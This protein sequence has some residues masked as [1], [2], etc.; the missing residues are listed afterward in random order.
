MLMQIQWKNAPLVIMLTEYLSP[1]RG[2]RKRRGGGM[3]HVDC[4]LLQVGHYKSRFA[5]W[6]RCRDNCWYFCLRVAGVGIGLECGA[7]DS[8]LPAQ[9]GKKWIRGSTG[10]KRFR[11]GITSSFAAAAAAAAAVCHVVCERL[12][13]WPRPR[14]RAQPNGLWVRCQ[15]V[16]V[17]AHPLFYFKKWYLELWPLKPCFRL[18]VARKF[19]LM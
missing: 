9:R 5:S 13:F 6:C 14:L 18:N 11:G 12:H 10:G 1:R 4:M 7:N 16:H 15:N 17:K 3:L 8:T 19:S 2:D